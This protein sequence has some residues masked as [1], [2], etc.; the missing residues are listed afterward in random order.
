MAAIR[1]RALEFYF[2]HI[3]GSPPEDVRL[4]DGVV[5]ALMHKLDIP[6][7]SSA[8]VK[9]VLHDILATQAAKKPYDVHGGARKRGRKPLIV[10]CTP[11]ATVVYEALEHGLSNTQAAVMVNEW[12][13]AQ[14]P[15]LPTLSWSAVE[16]FTQRST[17][18][19]RSRRV[20]KKSGKE[21]VGSPW[22]NARLAECEQ[23]K[24]Q[25]QLGLLQRADLGAS[26]PP[27]HPR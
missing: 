21:D 7:G 14:F 5:L 2:V 13:W 15:P 11:Q 4:R 3:C 27:S 9:K 20:T 24:R 26:G 8:E 18:I 22:A 10:D 17:V 1:R 25:L 12:R 16:A 23:F 6:P 19:D